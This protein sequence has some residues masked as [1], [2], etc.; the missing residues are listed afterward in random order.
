MGILTLLFISNVYAQSSV[1]GFQ[2]SFWKTKRYFETKQV[3]DITHTFE[4]EVNDKKYHGSLVI[5][6]GNAPST[7]NDYI[8]IKQGDKVYTT[9][10][11]C[12]KI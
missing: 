6:N 10:A 7:L 12:R 9:I 11:K 2:C 4:L 3:V 8:V 5:K 1:Q